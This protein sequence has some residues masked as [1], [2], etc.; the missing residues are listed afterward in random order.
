MSYFWVM[1]KSL[2]KP[3]LRSIKLLLCLLLVQFS[4]AQTKILRGV[5]KD[6]HSDER[7]P[8]ASMQ[9]KAEKN[10][11]L[12]DSAG[13][14]IFRFE[15]WP[16][17]TLVI[18]YVGYQ[19]FD[20]A[21]DSTLLSKVKGNVIDITIPLERAK[22]EAVIVRQKID[23]GYLMWKRIVKHKPKNDRYRFH[24]FSYELY[25]KLEIDLKNIKKEK[26]E[27]LP[28]IKKF[29]FVL[30]NI[31]TSEGAPYLPVYL[32]EALSDYY[33]Q[34]SPVRR[35]EVFK[36]VKT[37]GVNNESISKFLGGMEENIDFYSNFIPV[38]DKQF[39]SPLADF[40]DQYYHY[41]V[42]DTQYVNN[43]RLIHF[44]FVP[45][46]KGENTF[47]GDCWVH[48]PTW[49]IQKMNLRLTKE[50]NVN[51]VYMLSLIQE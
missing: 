15:E 38:F 22:Y 13:S 6:A 21:F 27:N 37:I 41:K 30:N 3:I 36:A 47:E 7:I 8:F 18:T 10:G 34:K 16:K 1:I 50:A 31:D 9:F 24:N 33:Y 45:K 20:L 35:R 4:H 32:T 28:F 11:R 12:S 48:D 49:A 2:K 25:N 44:F 42:L 40:G 43:Q 51:F 14:F 39:I 26:W 29:N 17:D 5:I 19:E 23:R 46:R